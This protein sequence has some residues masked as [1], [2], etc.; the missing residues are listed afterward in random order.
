M[1]TQSQD[2]EHWRSW[3]GSKS[4]PSSIFPGLPVL[5][6]APGHQDIEASLL[7]FLSVLLYCLFGSNWLP[8]GSEPFVFLS[9]DVGVKERVAQ[10]LIWNLTEEACELFTPER[11]LPM[12]DWIRSFGRKWE[13]P[14]FLIGFTGFW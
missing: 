9:C 10:E 8:P 13:N 12:S 6:P 4:T 2:R 14:P 5:R 7:R 11:C 1:R 3:P